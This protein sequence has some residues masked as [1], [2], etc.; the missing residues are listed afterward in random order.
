MTDIANAEVHVNDVGTRFKLTLEDGD[1]TAVNISTATVKR[2]DFRK[3]DGTV[4]QRTAAF[5]TTGA[6]GILYYDTIAG[7]IDQVGKWYV[8]PYVEFDG[9][10]GHGEKKSFPVFAVL[11]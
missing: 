1:N 2:L 11:E 7:D 10:K 9:F 4:I 8:Q 5:F 6:D 3:P